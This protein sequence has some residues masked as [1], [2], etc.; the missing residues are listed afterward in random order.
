M[1]H[2]IVRKTWV[3]IAGLSVTLIGVALLVLPGPGLVTIAAGLAILASEFVWA[4]KLIE[5]VKR[6]LEEAKTKI[7]ETKNSTRRR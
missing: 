4:Q 7:I 1:A 5:P 2:R 3:T 6:R